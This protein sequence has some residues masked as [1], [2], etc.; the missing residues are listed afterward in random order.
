MADYQK[1]L[2]RLEKKREKACIRCGA[3]CGAYEDPCLHLKK[4]RSGRYYCAIYHRRLGERKTEAGETFLCV[5]IREI[6]H[7]RWPGSHLCAYKKGFR[8]SQGI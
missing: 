6:L 3:C 7:T 8:R 5:P 2:R 1:H 4:Q